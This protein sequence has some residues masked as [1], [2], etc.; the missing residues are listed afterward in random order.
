MHT[1]NLGILAH[2]DAGKTSLTERLLHTAG[3]IDT[4]GSVDAGSTQTDSLALERRRGITIKSAVVSFTLGATTVNLIDTPGHP[5]FIAEVERVLGVLD[6]AVLVVSAVEGVQ[7]QTRVL[8]RTLRRLR[9][10]TLLF[11]N[12]TDRPGARYGSLL[13]SIT[14]R[15]SP[16]TVAMGSTQ[17]LGTRSATTTPF[18]GSDPGFTGALTDLLTRHDDELLTAYVDD[19]AALTHARLLESLAEQTARCR[20]HPVFFGSAATGSGIDALADGITGLLP[21]ATGDAEAPARG[22]VFKVDRTANGER[23]AYVRMFEGTVRAR[24]VLRFRSPDG[25]EGEDKVSAVT[26]F[27]DGGEVPVPAVHAGRI[28]RLKGLA[29]IRIGDSVGEARAE[30]GR[31]HFAP[32]TLETV[33]VPERPEDRGAL[34]VAL[35]RLAEQD[36]LIAV[37]R[38]DLR[39]EVS[40]SL[41]GEVQKEVIEATLADEFGVDVTF[42]A[43]TTIC[44]ERPA[45]RGAAV[46]IIDTDPN[47]FLATVGL[48]VDPAPYG[49]GVEFRREVELG[50]MPYSLMR[51]VEETVL[52]TLTQGIHGWQVTDC[53]VTQTHSGYWPRQSHSHGTFDKSMSSTAGD[54]RHLTPLVLMDALLRAGTQVY[55]PMHRFRLELP[56]DTFG[57]LVPVLA[58]LRAV[59][60]QPEMRGALCTLEGELPAARVHEL[61]QLL[62]GLTR[63]EGMMESA[64]DGHRP[65][66]GP[67]PERPRTDHD[68]LHRK[69]YLLRTVRRVAG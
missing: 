59:P 56:T 50:S 19:P 10:P 69:E 20:V 68:P 35:G 62:P 6:G 25:R 34:H 63:G 51:A 61:Q 2:V 52:S 43:T 28:G 7:A 39:Q 8:L 57:A 21:A 9:I 67:V 44:L 65:V 16:D 53:V 40:L 11:V 33:V 5:D 29:G 3:T 54:F 47:P 64:F 49:S 41:Y 55:E 22:T 48:R 38:D 58:R 12:K 60:G 32:P 4:L 46:E 31:R 15:L 36:P 18:T 24:E 37:R 23:T 14:E 13:T 27:E 66:T 1:L 17:H 45:G 30:A 42:R 26:V